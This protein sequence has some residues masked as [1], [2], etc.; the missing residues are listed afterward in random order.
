MNG[1]E[2]GLSSVQARATSVAGNRSR[3]MK[4][5]KQVEGLFLS[6][7]MEAMDQQ[8]FGE[9]M[10]GSSRATQLFRSRRNQ[11][12]ADEM[13]LRGELG[14]AEMLYHDL[15]RE[16]ASTPEADAA[17]ETAADTIER[18]EDR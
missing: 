13:G 5:C 12:I 7:L 8:T 6:R 1:S 16:A 18:G 4:A 10:L 14:L 9:G 15:T 2:P 11:A 17:A 3:L